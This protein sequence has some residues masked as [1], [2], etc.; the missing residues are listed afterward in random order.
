M[1]KLLNEVTESSPDVATKDGAPDGW[2]VAFPMRNSNLP[3]AVLGSSAIV[4]PFSQR[5]T[6]ASARRNLSSDADNFNQLN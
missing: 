2:T 4:D 3:G 6:N 5:P 1:I